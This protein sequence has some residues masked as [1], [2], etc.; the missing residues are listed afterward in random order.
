MHSWSMFFSTVIILR[1]ELRGWIQTNEW[2]K[3][4]HSPLND[5]SNSTPNENCYISW[6]RPDSLVVE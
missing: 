2:H 5:E 4:S 3:F 1:D 6:I